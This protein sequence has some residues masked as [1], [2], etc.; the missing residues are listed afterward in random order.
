MNNCHH[1]SLA[2]VTSYDCHQSV[3]RINSKSY[4]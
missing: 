2:G 1:Q 3:N 4:E